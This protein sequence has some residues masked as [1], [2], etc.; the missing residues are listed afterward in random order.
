MVRANPGCGGPVFETRSTMTPTS[1]APLHTTLTSGLVAL[2]LTLILF[3]VILCQVFIYLRT[4]NS[5]S[6]IFKALVIAIL[7]GETVHTAFISYSSYFY[8]VLNFGNQEV[9]SSSNLSSTFSVCPSC[10]LCLD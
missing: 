4:Y 1:A 2:C 8:M 6:R 7:I 10:L 9:T 5:D 3:G